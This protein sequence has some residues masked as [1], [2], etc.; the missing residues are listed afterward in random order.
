MK[1]V[2]FAILL[3]FSLALAYTQEIQ[4]GFHWGYAFYQMEELRS[5]NEHLMKEIP[6]NPQLIEDYPPF[7]YYRPSILVLWNRF[8]LG[9]TWTKLSTGSRYSLKDYSGE[10]L[11]DTRAKS[12]G[13]GI[14]YNICLNPQHAL[15]FLVCNEAGW[16][17]SRLT[18]EEALYLDGV[19]EIKEQYTFKSTDLYWEPGLKIAYSFSLFQIHLYAGYTNLIRGKGLSSKQNGEEFFMELK[20]KPVHAG[21]NGFRWGGGLAVNFTKL[22]QL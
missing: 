9:V 18:V 5:F 12:N 14:A 1:K 8:E 10:Y 16:L 11:F 4:V 13:P 15:R 22:H 6:L 20:S 2:T 3:F 21:W 17:T 7:Y 19:E